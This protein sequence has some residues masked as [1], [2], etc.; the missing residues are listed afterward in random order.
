MVVSKYIV[1]AH[2]LAVV[3]L[4]GTTGVQAKCLFSINSKLSAQRNI[5]NGSFWAMNKVFL[6]QP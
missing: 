2:I 4:L 1:I 5:N 6:K 3:F